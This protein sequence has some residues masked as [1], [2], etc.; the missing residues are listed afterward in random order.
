MR[1]QTS[2]VIS[3]QLCIYR[4]LKHFV[5]EYKLTPLTRLEKQVTHHKRVVHENSTLNFVCWQ[6]W[7]TDSKYNSNNSPS[8]STPKSCTVTTWVLSLLWH[9]LRVK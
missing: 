8:Y 6:H 5:S 1:N 3:F 7:Q 4:E 9:G 2:T